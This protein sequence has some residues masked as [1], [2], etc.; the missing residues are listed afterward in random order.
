[1]KVSANGLTGA[2]AIAIAAVDPV[3]PVV[4]DLRADDATRLRAV[5]FADPGQQ[6]PVLPAP[7][8]L[9]VALDPNSVAAPKAGVPVAALIFAAVDRVNIVSQP[10]R[11]PR[12]I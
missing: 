10:L 2:E 3:R 9:A 11:C 8:P 1:M 4:T 7:A 5:T 6:G 12:S